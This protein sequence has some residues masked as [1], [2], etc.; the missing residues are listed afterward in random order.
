MV[1][2]TINPYLKGFY[3]QNAETLK[4]ITPMEAHKEMIDNIG[5]EIAGSMVLNGGS[6]GVRILE[7]FS[8]EQVR[9]TQ[10][11]FAMH[12]F[13]PRHHHP[14]WC[15]GKVLSGVI[16]DNLNSEVYEKGEMFIY[17]PGKFHD[18]IATQISEMILFNTTNETVAKEI[19]EKGEYYYRGKKA[20]YQLY[21]IEHF[22]RFNPVTR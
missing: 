22:F 5:M 18:A 8:N 2:K 21:P 19:Y 7:R 4:L 10:L 20:Q 14:H 11:V 13:V 6:D 12:G 17:E 16:V 9:I 15:V 3:L 1:R